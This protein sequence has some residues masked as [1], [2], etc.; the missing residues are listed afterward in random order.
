MQR[1]GA[2]AYG[3]G[4]I[5]RGRVDILS[6]DAEQLSCNAYVSGSD[7]GTYIASDLSWRADRE[8][9]ELGQPHRRH[10]VQ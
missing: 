3:I 8:S 4:N 9:D 6:M 7:K 10:G 1:K 2:L 5:T